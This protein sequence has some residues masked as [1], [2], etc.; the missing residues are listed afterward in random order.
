MTFYFIMHIIVMLSRGGAAR[1]LVGLITRRS[2][3]SNPVPA[4]NK[5]TL[6]CLFILWRRSLVGYSV[7]FIPE[8]SKVRISPPLPKEVLT[9]FFL[10][11]FL[12]LFCFKKLIMLFNILLN[13]KNSIYRLFF[14]LI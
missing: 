13:L 2:R 6:S 10:Q 8:R 5:A 7:R 14:Y 9:S 1:Q 4:T 11:I 3:G 12:F